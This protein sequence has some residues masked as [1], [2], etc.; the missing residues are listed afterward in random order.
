MTKSSH[1]K[2]KGKH[3]SLCDLVADIATALGH[4]IKKHVEYEHGEID[5]YIDNHI[6]AEIKSNSTDK[7]F[8]KAR[9]QCK[10]AGNYGM[11]DIGYMITPT[12]V[13]KV[14]DKYEEA[15]IKYN[16]K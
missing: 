15:N 1:E 5:V 10:R 14:Y 6:Y 2:A 13:T 12:E 9:R 8:V 7:G 11:C 16:K 3:D 4:H